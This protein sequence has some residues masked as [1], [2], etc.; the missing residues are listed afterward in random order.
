MQA[1]L[2]MHSHSHQYKK[3]VPVLVSSSCALCFIVVTNSLLFVCSIFRTLNPFSLLKKKIL[4]I[5]SWVLLLL[6]AQR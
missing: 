5:H 2:Q 3:D 4:F 1:L 6:Q